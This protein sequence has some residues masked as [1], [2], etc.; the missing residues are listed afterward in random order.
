MYYCLLHNLHKL[1]YNVYDA[2]VSPPYPTC[3]TGK[4]ARAGNE[5]RQYLGTGLYRN[6][7]VLRPRGG[8]KPLPSVVAAMSR[9]FATGDTDTESSEESS[10]EEQ[11]PV[12]QK[13][14]R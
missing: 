2:P 14:V 7:H 6:A 9:F 3:F 12:P 1:A 11:K 13:T 8:V 5:T 4:C 10:E